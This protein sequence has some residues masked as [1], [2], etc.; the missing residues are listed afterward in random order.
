MKIYPTKKTINTENSI[1]LQAV[2]MA[3]SVKCLLYRNEDKSSESQHSC[4]RL[5]VVVTVTIPAEAEAGGSW[6]LTS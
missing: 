5:N 3:W 6:G 2:K 4:K 1:N